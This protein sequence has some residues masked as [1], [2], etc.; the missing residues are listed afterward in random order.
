MRLL[1]TV[2]SV[3][4]G[5]PKSIASSSSSYLQGVNRSRENIGP[6]VVLT[7]YRPA[8]ASS[9][10]P[11]PRNKTKLIPAAQLPR[12]RTLSGVRQPCLL[13]QTSVLT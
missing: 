13:W 2:G 8:A 11:S 1:S 5:S 7:V 9:A 4:W 12:D 6:K 10:L 3:I